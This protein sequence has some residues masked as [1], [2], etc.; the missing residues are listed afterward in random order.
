MSKARPDDS[1]SLP[2][3]ETPGLPSEG[4]SPYATGAGGVAFERMVAV[5][6]LA[7]LLVG[8]GAPE[9]GDG[10]CLVSV[11]FQQAPSEPVDD[12]V[13]SA[14]LP[15]ESAPSLVL[16]LAVRRAPNLVRSDRNAQALVR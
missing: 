5:H 8:S 10:R 14:A 2:P 11:G 1:H 3:D 9:F 7:H 4:M 16:A 12:L 13:L 15:E 6:Y